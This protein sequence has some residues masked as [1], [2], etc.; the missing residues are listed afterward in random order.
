MGSSTQ[1]NL[2]CLFNSM[3]TKFCKICSCYINML[4]LTDRGISE[5]FLRRFLNLRNIQNY[6]IL[7]KEMPMKCDITMKILSLPFRLKESKI[8]HTAPNLKR[9]SFLSISW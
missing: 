1:V 2:R 3:T 8:D 4:W 5:K 9:A 7:S 6:A